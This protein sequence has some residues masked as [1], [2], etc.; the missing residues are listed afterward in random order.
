M[1]RIHELCPIIQV[2]IRSLSREE[3]QFITENKLS[4]FYMPT[5][6]ENKNFEKQM[7]SSLS[8]DV[9]VTID[10]DVLDP[11]IMPAVGTPEA[12][13]PPVATGFEDN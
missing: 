4:V 13:W 5:L 7:L 11:S 12:C 2:G 1:R 10:V 3:K 6:M 9:Y 8:D